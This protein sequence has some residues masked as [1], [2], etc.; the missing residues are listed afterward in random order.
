MI[1]TDNTFETFARGLIPAKEQHDPDT[2]RRARA[3]Y[4]NFAGPHAV[5]MDDLELVQMYLELH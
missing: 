1:V 3:W 2:V 4:A 5:K